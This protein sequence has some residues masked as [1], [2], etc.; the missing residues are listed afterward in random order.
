MAQA[1]E[2]SKSTVNRLWRLHNIKPHLSRNGERDAFCQTPEGVGSKLVPVIPPVAP[3]VS[4]T[5]SYVTVMTPDME[6]SLN[7]KIRIA[8][9]GANSRDY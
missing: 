5:R 8:F 3:L 6:G 9:G 2:V 1:Q 7:L 4:F